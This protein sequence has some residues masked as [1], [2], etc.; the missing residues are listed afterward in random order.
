LTNES[1]FE[2]RQ[3]P[4]RFAIVG[5]GPIGCEIAQAFARFGSAVTIIERGPRILAREDADAAAIVQHSLQLDGVRFAF[6]SELV[7]VEGNGNGLARLSVVCGA[8]AREFEAD[9][10]M[11]GVGRS[12]AVDGLGLD[13]AGV[14]HDATRGVIVDDYLRTSNRRIYAAGDVCLDAK[15]THTADAAA[16]I[17]IRNALFFGR[18]KQSALAIPWCTYT[19]PEIA[20]VG[21]YPAAAL[22]RG[23][24]VV[25]EQI[26]FDTV[27]R[28]IL[29]GRSEGFVRVL[30]RRGNSRILGATVVGADA[31]EMVSTLTA[32][33]CRGAELGD[34][35]DVIYPYPTRME[36]IRKLA[37]QHNRRRLTPFVQRL[38][39]R[40]LAWRRG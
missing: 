8:S 2:L 31:G 19:D 40:F 29:D 23:L 25:E 10:V 4:R 13:A 26:R 22:E 28:A 16:R 3:L 36:A 1:V 11:L 7:R 24:D 33:I 5:G 30:R 35:A 37:D 38:L 39:R 20:H 27:D 6:D 32:A 17:V 12:P 34:L 9:A 21:L 18:R 14:Q 15:F